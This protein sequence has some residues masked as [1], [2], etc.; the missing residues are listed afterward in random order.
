M[1][2]HKDEVQIKISVG[3]P[4]VETS[5]KPGMKNL[6]KRNTAK[7]NSS[8]K[9]KKG[10]NH[11]SYYDEFTRKDASQDL[12]DFQQTWESD[13]FSIKVGGDL[14]LNSK[15]QRNNV[16]YAQSREIT[17]VDCSDL[18]IPRDI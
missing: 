2:P 6:K 18:P 3:E 7:I 4:Q 12:L 1:L 8:K 13:Y 10:S 11:T 16:F 5:K 17:P 15:S 14:I 9:Q